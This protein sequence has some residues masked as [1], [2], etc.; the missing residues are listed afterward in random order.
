MRDAQLL[1]V[2]S[3]KKDLVLLA[4]VVRSSGGDFGGAVA[5]AAAT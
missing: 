1:A 4:I 3:T 5:G 2:G